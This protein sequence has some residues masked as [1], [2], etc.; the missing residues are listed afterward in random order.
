MER[1]DTPHRQGG[2]VAMVGETE[3]VGSAGD[4]RGG[5]VVLL[6]DG[7]RVS[8]SLISG[9]RAGCACGWRGPL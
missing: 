3:G 6:A 2:P 5:E 1:K 8:A 4:G 9:W 7:G